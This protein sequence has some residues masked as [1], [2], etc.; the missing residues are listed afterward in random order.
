VRILSGGASDEVQAGGA[1]IIRDNETCAVL[2]MGR[3][4]DPSK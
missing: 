2:F 3:V 4:D 1:G